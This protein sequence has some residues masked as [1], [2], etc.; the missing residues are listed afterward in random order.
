MVVAAPGAHAFNTASSGDEQTQFNT[1]ASRLEALLN[2]RDRQVK[3][4]M[5][6]YVATNVSEEYLGKEQRWNAKAQE[7]R[8][9]I[10]LLRQ[11]LG[12]ND[13]TALT[14]LK[15]A[16]QAVASVETPA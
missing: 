3:A 13:E 15:K 9:I 8:N 16:A 11:S 7:V 14:A 5:A 6:R 1:V 4:A 12:Q 10:S 2:L